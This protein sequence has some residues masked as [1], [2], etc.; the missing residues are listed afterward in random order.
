MPTKKFRPASRSRKLG[1]SPVLEQLA[2]DPAGADHADRR[3]RVALAAGDRGPQ[4]R[5]LLRELL[6]SA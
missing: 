2:A 1:D 6:L 4:L 3:L 5:D